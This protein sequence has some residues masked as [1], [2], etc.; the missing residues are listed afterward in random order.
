MR[1]VVEF[2][3]QL[4]VEEDEEVLPS[5]HPKMFVALMESAP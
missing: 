4:E 1:V 3:Q 5:Y 2:A